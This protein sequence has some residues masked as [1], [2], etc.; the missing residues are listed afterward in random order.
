MKPAGIIAIIV[1]VVILVGGGIYVYTNPALAEKFGLRPTPAQNTTASTTPNGARFGGN[2][3]GFATGSI[4]VLNGKAFTITL[5]DGSTKDIDTTATTT[6]ENYASASSAPATTTIN[7][8][9]VGEQV[10]VMGSPN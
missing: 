10:F 9:S 5:S 6:F 4:E 8:L 3:G 7:Q 2:R 1:V